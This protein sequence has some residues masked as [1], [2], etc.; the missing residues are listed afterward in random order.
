MHHHSPCNTRNTEKMTR[1]QQNRYIKCI[2]AMKDDG[3]GIDRKPKKLSRV[4]ALVA[5][6]GRAHCVVWE[7]ALDVIDVTAMRTALTPSV[8]TSDW[9]MAVNSKKTYF[10]GTCRIKKRVFPWLITGIY[11]YLVL[12][13][14]ALQHCAFDSNSNNNSNRRS[15]IARMQLS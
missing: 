9:Q 12:N 2:V 4:F 3:F 6:S 10:F 11:D 5:A 13:N 8:Q 1:R 14:L 15:H 7:P